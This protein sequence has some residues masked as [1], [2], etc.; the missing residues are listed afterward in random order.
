MSYCGVGGRHPLGGVL[1]ILEACDLSRLSA[2]RAEAVLLRNAAIS[3][4]GSRPMFM[5]MG[6][7]GLDPRLAEFV[8]EETTHMAAGPLDCS[9]LKTASTWTLRRESAPATSLRSESV[10]SVRAMAT[11]MGPVPSL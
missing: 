7:R 6:G 1:K 9:A 8:D 11:L 4:T 3:V 10:R 2:G 5:D